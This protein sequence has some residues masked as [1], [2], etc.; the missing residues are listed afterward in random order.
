MGVYFQPVQ[1]G[2]FGATDVQITSGLQAGEQIL[3][4]L[5]NSSSSAST[6]GQSGTGSGGIGIGRVLGGGGRAFS[7]GGGGRRSG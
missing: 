3:L 2:L 1:V 4:A 6:A 7:G 5:P